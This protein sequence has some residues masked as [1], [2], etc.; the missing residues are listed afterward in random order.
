MMRAMA[1]TRFRLALILVVL[2]AGT[3][4]R[5]AVAQSALEVL[6]ARLVNRTGEEYVQ[7]RE[8]AVS[9]PDALFEEIL[10]KLDAADRVSIERLLASALRI[11]RGQPALAAEFDAHLRQSIEHPDR[12]T[13]TGRPK[14]S[15]WWPGDR[16]EL[17][18][19][20]FEVILKRYVPEELRHSFVVRLGRPNPENVDRLLALAGVDGIEYCGF[21]D[22]AAIGDL[23]VQ[24]RITPMIVAVYKQWR[25]RGHSS[26][27]TLRV[28]AGF[29][30][31]LQLDALKE[32]RTF[33]VEQCHREGVTPWDDDRAPEHWMTATAELNDAKARLRQ[34]QIEAHIGRIPHPDIDDLERTVEV[35]T[36]ALDA[37]Q[38]RKQLRDTWVQLERV[39]SA[40]EAQLRDQ[41]DH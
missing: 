3:S 28:L 17:D 15:A 6:H 31:Q 24:Q 5:V 14:Y 25:E 34:A 1:S 11:R 33:E 2:L 39:I 40:L 21:L 13:K 8:A 35:R 23:Q 30:S 16:F 22:G 10:R 27:G 20:S 18:P 7:A 19:L 29:G 36:R 12:L 32:I 38:R 9:L 4:D 26:A 41:E 37:A